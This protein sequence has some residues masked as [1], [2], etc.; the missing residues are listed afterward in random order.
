MRLEFGMAGQ[1]FLDFIF[2][3][4]S[5]CWILFVHAEAKI[6]FQKQKANNDI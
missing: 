4:T 3:I 5:L 6:T 1:F 2:R